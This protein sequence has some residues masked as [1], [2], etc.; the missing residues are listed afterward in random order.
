MQ[1]YVTGQILTEEEM[2]LVDRAYSLFDE[3]KNANR[4]YHNE[5]EECRKIALLE[6]PNQDQSEMD[7]AEPTPQLQTLRSSLIC[8]IADQMDNEPAAVIRP[9]RPDTQNLA[10][11]LTDLVGRVTYQNGFKQLHRQRVEDFFVTG[12][13]VTQIVW[14]EDANYGQGDIALIRVPVEDM[15]FDPNTNDVQESRAVFRCSWHPHEWYEEHYPDV[16]RFVH[17]DQYFNEK[18]DQSV[19]RP[20]IMMMEYWYREYDAKKRRYR[21]HVAYLAGHVLL[22]NSKDTLKNGVYEH[23]QYPFV[24]DVFTEIVGKMY[25]HGMVKEFAPMMRAINRY[26]RYMDENARASSKMRL[27]VNTAA[28]LSEE[29]LRDWTKQIVKGNSINENA[30]R[31]FQTVPLS[32]TVSAQMANYIDLIKQDSGQNEFNR[33]E[34][35]GGITAASAIVSLQ[36][37]GGKTT[38]LRTEVLKYGSEKMFIQVLWLIRQ[39]YEN[40]RIM[41]VTGANGKDRAI[42]MDKKRLFGNEVMMPYAVRVQVQKNNPLRVQA[43]NDNILQMFNVLVQGGQQIDPML[44][45]N[46]LQLD[47]KDRLLAAIEESQQPQML[48]MAQN[49]QAMQ[50]TIEQQQADINNLRAA[51]DAEADKLTKTGT[52]S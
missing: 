25:G 11:D 45:V 24:V 8:C 14:D 47:G 50:G 49:A 2:K 48:Q 20:R 6:D 28:G 31:W 37:A 22:Y 38:R 3:F 51:M 10:E 5:V 34:S 18:D 44:I 13:S 21:V 42:L 36:E 16:G 39:F 33:G 32:A 35:G 41:M 26:A 30:V 1:D 23:G 9:E 40:N 12:T 19:S 17:E 4:Y 7:D 46:A 27:L 43:E 29:D 52:I 15:Q